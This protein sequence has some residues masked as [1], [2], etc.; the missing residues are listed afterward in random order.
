MTF[1]HELVTREGDHAT[2]T[3]NR[4]QQRNALSLQH[5]QELTKAFEQVALTDAGLTGVRE[6]GFHESD[7]P[8]IDKVESSGRVLNG[9]GVIAEG[10]KQRV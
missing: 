3:M 2:I 10:I 9:A 5:L 1:E 6:R 8:H 4:P 7:I